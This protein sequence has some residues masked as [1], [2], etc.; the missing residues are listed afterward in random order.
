MSPKIHKTEAEWQR[1]LSPEQ[2]RV[3]RQGGTEL[4]FTGKYHDCKEKGVYRCRCCGEALFSWETKFDSGTGWP[5]FLAPIAPDGVTTRPD[6]SLGMTRVEVLCN[7]C[8]AHLGHVFEDGPLPT[9]QR[10]CMNS[11]CLDFVQDE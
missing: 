8:D 7:T 10:Y 11:V 2:F 9:H 5:S 4:A 3:C 6:S 1:E